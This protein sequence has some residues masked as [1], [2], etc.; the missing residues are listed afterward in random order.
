MGHGSGDP[1]EYN[2]FY[3]DPDWVRGE[4]LKALPMLEVLSRPD[5]FGQ[6]EGSE[7][8]RLRRQLQDAKKGQDNRVSELEATIEQLLKNQEALVK[9]MKELEKRIKL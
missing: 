3:T 9:G 6:V 5:P 1:N 4:Y 2:K 8:E 7:V